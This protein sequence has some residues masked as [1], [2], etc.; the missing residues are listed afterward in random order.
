MNG[1]NQDEFSVGKLTALPYPHWILLFGSHN[2]F[3]YR[4][5]QVK[6]KISE[7]QIDRGAYNKQDFER[8]GYWHSQKQM[9]AGI[10]NEF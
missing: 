8:D 6:T 3:L 9:V 4:L 5:E 2:P 7:N 1:G 10:L